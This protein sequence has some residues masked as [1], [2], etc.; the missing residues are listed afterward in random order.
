MSGDEIPIPK[1]KLTSGV[2]VSLPPLTHKDLPV[3]QGSFRLDGRNYLQWSELIRHT[4]ISRKK[5]SYIEEKAPAETDPQYD[6]WRE[7]NSLTP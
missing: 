5:I 4:L 7:E 3:L 6:T 2:K 1:E